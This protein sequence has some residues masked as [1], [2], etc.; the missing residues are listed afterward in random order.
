MQSIY[1]LIKIA[2]EPWITHSNYLHSYRERR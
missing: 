1:C 2:L